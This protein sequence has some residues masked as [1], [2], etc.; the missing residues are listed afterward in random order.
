M[1]H[2]KLFDA[3]SESFVELSLFVIV[4]F[5]F[6]R[7]SSCFLDLL[8]FFFSISMF[9]S[10]FTMKDSVTL[11]KHGHAKYQR[12]NYSNPF[13]YKCMSIHGNNGGIAPTSLRRLFTGLSPR[14]KKPTNILMYS[15]P[16]RLCFRMASS[17][18]S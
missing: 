10:I 1:F 11:T 9:I 15:S 4:H 17:I 8:I 12:K 16:L 2:S 7:S 13:N 18:I 3:L 5:P 14:I 6:R